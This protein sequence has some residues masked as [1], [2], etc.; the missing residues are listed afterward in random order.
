MKRLELGAC[1]QRVQRLIRDTHGYCSLGK[2]VKYLKKN[3]NRAQ[4]NAKFQSPVWTNTWG[5][6]EELIATYS[7]YEDTRKSCLM[8]YLQLLTIT[9]SC[10]FYNI[11]LVPAV[12]LLYLTAGSRIGLLARH[13]Y[14]TAPPMAE[15][16]NRDAQGRG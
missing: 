9:L 1:H 11:Q 4:S 16:E 14:R 6:L 3:E 5:S 15:G 10:I 2:D 12:F 8:R 7:G 13:R